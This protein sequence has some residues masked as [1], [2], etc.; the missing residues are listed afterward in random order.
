[1]EKI[2]DIQ[3]FLLTSSVYGGG[4]GDSSGY[5]YDSGDGYGYGYGS[6]YGAGSGDGSGLG[7][8]S[9][10]GKKSYLGQS[11]Y[12]IDSIPTLIDRI[13]GDSAKGHIINADLTTTPCWIA[14]QGN[15]FAHGRTLHEAAQAVMAKY[16][17]DRPLE[18]RIGEFVK[19][20]P[21]LEE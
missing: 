1:M 5:G 14:K 11:V 4:D 15:F 9:G 7:S 19:T 17:E 18:E 6:G 12:Y 13:W 8:G 2:D 16:L 20:H 21:D 10:Y 3:R